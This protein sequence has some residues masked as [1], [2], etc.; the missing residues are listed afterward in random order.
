M[1]ARLAASV[2]LALAVAIGAAGCTLITPQA[3]LEHYEPSDGVGGET[4]PVAIRNALLISNEGEDATLVAGFVSTDGKPH[5]VNVQYE[6]SE[7]KQNLEV[8]VPVRGVLG[9][10]IDDLEP[11]VLR[12]I[13]VLPGS[14][15]PVYFQTGDATGVQLKL[16]VLTEA[17]DY[18][19]TLAPTPTPTPTPTATTP[20]PEQSPPESPQPTTA[21]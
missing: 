11:K 15:F 16:P 14:L 6:N 5:M 17:L 3:T 20:A 7:G 10:T 9:L 21:P 8:R 19:S 2:V 12:D 1:K 4:G 18:Y 13:N